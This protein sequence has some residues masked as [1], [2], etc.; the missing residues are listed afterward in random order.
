M[1]WERGKIL[2]KYFLYKNILISFTYTA[3]SNPFKK[4]ENFRVETEFENDGIICFK[5]GKM[6]NIQ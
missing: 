6:Q 5:W 4:V 1:N 3:A 2:L